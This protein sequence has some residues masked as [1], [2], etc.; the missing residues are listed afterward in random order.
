MLSAT[1]DGGR[2]GNLRRQVVLF[3]CV[4]LTVAR[5]ATTLFMFVKR[6]VPW[7]EAASGG[8]LI[9]FMFFLFLRDG[10]RAPQPLAFADS[11]GALLSL[12]GS[13]VGTASEYSRHLWK[14]RPEN[15]GH[16]YPGGLFRYCRH[17]N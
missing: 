5:A 4:V 1:N 6:E 12:G 13:Y 11:V 9:G 16:V 2:S 14:S 3:A 15:E 7:G 8:G 10:L 17:I